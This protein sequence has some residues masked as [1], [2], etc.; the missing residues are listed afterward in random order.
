MKL[1]SA[2]CF[3]AATLCA[4]PVPDALAVRPGQPSDTA[5]VVCAYRGI[6]AQ[7]P[8]PKLRNPDG[9]AE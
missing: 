5:E 4:L 1:A 6:A 2:C 7:H 9:L 3:A 8:D